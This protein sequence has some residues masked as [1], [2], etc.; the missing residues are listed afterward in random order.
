MPTFSTFKDDEIEAMDHPTEPNFVRLHGTHARRLNR[1]WIASI[2]FNGE[3]W[4]EEQMRVGRLF[5]SAPRLA[6]Q[7]RIL[8]EALVGLCDSQL[9]SRDR[10]SAIANGLS[11]LEATKEGT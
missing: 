1:D 2:Q 9:S 6:E 11:A 10:E 5:A 8:R 3:M 7:I 4:P